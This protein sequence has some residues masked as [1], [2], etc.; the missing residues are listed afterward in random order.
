M[1]KMSQ[2]SEGFFAYATLHTYPSA[3]VFDLEAWCFNCRLNIQAMVD[4]A[5]NYLNEILHDPET[6][7]TSKRR[8]RH[9]VATKNHGR[10]SDVR[11]V[12][13]GHL[14]RAGA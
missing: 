9:T 1:T 4:H 6:A 10:M 13:G 2:G 8:I 12:K 11:P 3:Q 5:A 7:G 14:I